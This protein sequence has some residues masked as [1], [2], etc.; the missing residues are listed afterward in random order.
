MKP[1]DLQNLSEAYNQVLLSEGKSQSK[2]ITRQILELSEFIKDKITL[3]GL[4]RYL[5]NEGA[6]IK[7]SDIKGEGNIDAIIVGF[8]TETTGLAKEDKK[9]VSKRT[10]A[11]YVAPR[12]QIYELAAIAYDSNFKVQELK[13]NAEDS[14]GVVAKDATFHGKTI[15]KG[16]N[17]FNDPEKIFQKIVSRAKL[18]RPTLTTLINELYETY[19]QVRTGFKL[20]AAGRDALATKMVEFTDGKI[21]QKTATGVAFDLENM[22]SIFD[23]MGMTKYDKSEFKGLFT[24][25]QYEVEQFSK[26]ISLIEN[27]LNFLDKVSNGRDCYIIAHNMAYDQGMVA[28]AI[29]SFKQYAEMFGMQKRYN[30]VKKMYDQYFGNPEFILDTKDVAKK[31]LVEKDRLTILEKIMSDLP[32]VG[33]IIKKITSLQK[34]KAGKRSLSMGPMSSALTIQNIDWHTAANDVYVM[35]ELMKTL[36]S[37][38][39][40]IHELM[41]INETGNA[42]PYVGKELAEYV[43]EKDF[44]SRYKG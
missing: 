36:G 31:V 13:L 11:E 10:G 4:L 14:K 20:D 24:G 39:R 26:E 12:N 18:D 19:Q 21:N 32:E 38:T 7:D 16:L 42:P 25:A 22:F 43:I 34:T 40:V 2:A 17:K 30:K 5:K 27:F 3:A 15:Q 37:I 8:D 23:I 1:S 35:I 6:M 9:R 33:G 41:K 44:R 29:D 28:G